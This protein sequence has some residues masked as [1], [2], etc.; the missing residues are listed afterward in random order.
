MTP[1]PPHNH[2]PDSRS[3]S[4]SALR[5]A[6]A[7]VGWLTLCFAAAGTSLFVTTDGWFESLRKP[8]WNPPPWIFGPV[9]TLLY[10]MMA[11]AA[12]LV[13]RDGGWKAHRRAL[14]V[15][16]LQVLFNAMWTPL[17]FAAHQPGVAFLDIVLLWI[18]LAVTTVLF[19]RI[20]TLAGLLLLPYL[21]WTTFAAVLNFTIWRM[22]P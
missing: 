19:W 10:A 8:V 21:G 18:T 22:N 20:S 17:F 2:A 12:W 4:V 13:W 7:L 11:V 3:S 15:F 16:C 14:G 6:V 1:T 9:W 5:Q